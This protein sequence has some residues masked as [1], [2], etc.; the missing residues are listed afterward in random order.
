[1]SV[2]AEVG[3][4]RRRFQ[5]CAPSQPRS[6]WGPDTGGETLVLTHLTVP[7]VGESDRVF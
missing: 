6:V 1:M 2:R 3:Q 4:V 7:S 5:E